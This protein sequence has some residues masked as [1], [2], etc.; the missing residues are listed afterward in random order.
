MSTA[1]T[2]SASKGML[3]GRGGAG[4]FGTKSRPSGGAE[5]LVTPTLKSEHYTTGRGGG[6]N[7]VKNENA[8]VARLAQDVTGPAPKER[9]DGP[10]HYGRGGAANVIHASKTTEHKDG[11][12]KK[13]HEG[14]GLLDKLIGKHEKK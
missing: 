3:S 10:V 5:D 12:Q 1:P 4:N 7:I 13:A 6:G 14:K 11:E 9:D 8:D 2:D